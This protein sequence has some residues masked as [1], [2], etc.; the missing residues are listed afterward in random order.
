LGLEH[1]RLKGGLIQGCEDLPL[2]DR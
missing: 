2:F 1:N